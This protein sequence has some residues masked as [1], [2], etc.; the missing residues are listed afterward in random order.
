MLVLP[1]E[2]SL[3]PLCAAVCSCRP[4]EAALLHAAAVVSC[5]CWCKWPRT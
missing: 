2:C 4:P 1:S 3:G 5:C